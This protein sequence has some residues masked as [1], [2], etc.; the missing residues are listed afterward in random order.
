MI[1]KTQNSDPTVQET[2][3]L[4][5]EN[6]QENVQENA[7]KSDT[8]IKIDPTDPPK[9]KLDK[10][11]AKQWV[12]DLYKSNGRE[13]DDASATKFA[14][15]K[16]I[17]LMMSRQFRITTGKV[18]EQKDLDKIYGS[19][20]VDIDPV[21]EV[22]QNSTLLNNSIPPVGI[23]SQNGV[24]EKKNPLLT[25]DTGS[26]SDSEDGS[27]S[28]DYEGFFNGDKSYSENINS[29]PSSVLNMDEEDAV[30]VL[31]NTLGQYGVKVNAGSDETDHSGFT[32]TRPDGQ[33]QSFT[34]FSDLYKSRLKVVNPGQDPDQLQKERHS[35]MLNFIN[36][37]QADNLSFQTNKLKMTDA[38]G[39]PSAISGYMNGALTPST[40]DINFV[41]NLLPNGNRKTSDYF[42]G[43]GSFRYELW[44]SDVARADSGLSKHKGIQQKEDE[45]IDGTTK[46]RDNTFVN[47]KTIPKFPNLDPNFNINE[48]SKNRNRKEGLKKIKALATTFNKKREIA[49]A[50]L[51]SALRVSG[52]YKKVDINNPAAIAQIRDAGLLPGD[53]PMDQILINGKPSSVNEIS[54]MLY[55]YNNVKAIRAGKINIEIGDPKT[56][57]VLSSQIA[58]IK[59]LI[60]TQEAYDNEG[61]LGFDNGFTDW[62]NQTQETIE[63]VGTEIGLS[64]WELASNISYIGYDSLIALGVPDAAAQEIMYG[65]F[66]LPGIGNF[67]R[68]LDPDFVRKARTEYQPVY[69][70]DI[71]DSDSFGEGIYKSSTAVSSS[72]VYT[73]VFML[74]PAAGLAVTGLGSYGGDRVSQ[75]QRIKELKEKQELGFILSPDEQTMLNQSGAMSRLNSLTKAGVEVGVTSLF[76]YKFFKGV[77][78]ASNFKGPKTSEN[79]A[80]IA[81]QYA[82]N[83]R[84]TVAGKVARYLGIDKKAILAELPEENIIALTNYYTDVAFGLDTWD[85]ERAKK[86]MKE[87]SLVSVISGQTTGTAIKIYQNNKIKKI[88]EQQIKNNMNLPAE[89]QA[90]VN[91]LN[92]DAQVNKI[93]KDAE[94]NITSLEN[95]TEYKVLKDLQSKSDAQVNKFED[96]KNDLVKRMSVNEKSKFLDIIRQIEQQ[97]DNVSS[98]DTSNNVKIQSQKNIENLKIEGRKILSKY[99]SDMSF[100]FADA[101]VKSE[102]LAKAVEIIGKEKVENGEQNFTISND[103]PAV[104][105]RAAQL[106]TQAV[107]DGIVQARQNANAAEHIGLN[108]ANDFLVKVDRQELKDWNLSN[109]IST[110]KDMLSVQELDLETTQPIDEVSAD[111]DTNIKVTEEGGI[112]VGTTKTEKTKKQINQERTGSILSRIESFNINSDFANDL[113]IKQY[114]DLKIFFDNVKSGKKVS[115]GKIESILDAHDIAIQIRSNA[116]GKIKVGADLKGVLKEDGS[117]TEKGLKLYN[118]LAQVVSGKIGLNTMTMEGLTLIKDTQIGAPLHN[119]IQ[120]GLRSSAEAQQKAGKIKTQHTDSYKAEVIA[121]NKA[122]GTSYSTDPR[123]SVDSSYEMSLLSMLKRKTGETNKDGQDVEFVRAKKLI[124]EELQLRKLDS[125]ATFNKLQIANGDKAAAIEKY[126]KY[127]DAIEKLGITDAS[128]FEDV[129]SKALPFNLNAIN[130]LS[131]SMPGD[132]AIDRINDFESYEAFS[133]EQGSYT[134]IFMSKSS[135]GTGFNDYFGPSNND[136][137]AANSGKNVTRPE[138]LGSDLRLSPGMYWDN[139]YGQLNGMEM[140]ISGKKNFQTLDNLLSNPTFLE[141][142]EDGVLKDAL[143]DNFSKRS[144]MWQKEVRGSNLSP[145]DIGDTKKMATLNKFFN[146]LYGG[147]SAISLARI[148]QPMSQ[149]YSAVSGTYPILKNSRAKKYVQSRGVGFLGGIA[150]SF[151]T[152]G[153]KKR[154]FGDFGTQGNLSN[155]YDKSRTGLRNALASQLAIDRNQSMPADYYIK[156]LNL[157]DA[158]GKE[159]TSVGGQLTLDRVFETLGKSNEM[160]LNFMLA[161]SDK[162]AAN[163]AFEAHYL[164]YKLSQGENVSDIDAFWEKENANPDIEAIKYADQIIDRTMRQSDATGEAQVYESNISKNVMRTFMP[165]QKFIL[166]AKADFS[167]QLSILQDPN[168]SELQKRDA[169]NYMQGKFN[170]IISFNAIKYAGSLA[171]LKGL[172]GLLSLGMDEDDVFEFGGIEGDISKRLP[173]KSDIDDLNSLEASVAGSKTLEERNAA[174]SA[175]S[176]FRE[177]N[178]VVKGFE[179]YAMNYDNKFSTGKSYPVIGSTI[180]DAIQTLNPS[181]QLG[182]MNDMMAWGVNHVYGED[183]AREFSSRSLTSEPMDV[184]SYLDL[185]LSK[186]G[187]IGIG[188]ETVTRLSDAI[189]LRKNGTFTINQGDYKN[190][191]VYLTAP[192]DEM[193]QKLANSVDFLFQLRCHAIMNPIAPRADLDKYADRLERT[194][195]KYFTQ[196]KPDPYMQRIMGMQGPLQEEN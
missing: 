55:D 69:E 18:P 93:E 46:V 139:A 116:S 88:G 101:T 185:A 147:V 41:I 61:I 96:M 67:K 196:S 28:L 146:T 175:L 152:N 44:K 103:D 156:G 141:S 137:I 160:A 82:K 33:S 45:Y 105:D 134:P 132:R 149:F 70:G 144:S 183:I 173:I 7:K 129:S 191:E 6:T 77:K 24:E 124:L 107:A 58:Q 110:V 5:Q 39:L 155:I 136:G 97:N 95:N 119:L 34:I 60:R 182:F 75:N 118:S 108:N 42:N 142:F 184:D 14:E 127:K 32:I 188:V 167:V 157:T 86:M 106:H 133:F 130:R 48:Q 68:T 117:L 169:R 16:N 64:T 10:S 59:D 178:D 91:K 111:K 113:P 126:K 29:I 100:Y 17:K 170:E 145:V 53:L 161:N 109:D 57:G 2:Q 150:G 148:T 128:S 19:W 25:Q 171:T 163:I 84:Q 83:V 168:I 164:D 31:N 74:N 36:G 38:A 1:V 50:N 114:E 112:V 80:K 9:K 21:D 176:G 66:G 62:L 81:N 94:Q 115:Y 190:K 73:G 12:L 92:I 20:E 76:T 140:E 143:L 177:M 90:I 51:G 98:D 104:F 165:F 63:G 52:A 35:K 138:T 99:P 153:N 40:E 158:Q 180:Q 37:S 193:R 192:N 125:E 189:K 27:S 186:A 159:L 181:P 89:N 30:L 47:K 3:P 13:I 194:I 49:S 131:E 85:F 15:H 195:E 43:D 123:S 151:N 4:V 162:A 22:L 122:N 102:Y 87:T 166:N 71:L 8:E 54:T 72:L 79:S 78:N 26:D 11:K 172:S 121:Y 120:E 56:A 179:Q 187:M 174:L 65:N 154:R 23:E 135:D